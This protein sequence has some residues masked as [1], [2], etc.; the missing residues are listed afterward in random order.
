VIA[1]AVERHRLMTGDDSLE[2]D[3]GLEL[4]VETA[5]LWISLGH[6]DA[7]GD[8]HI[9]GVTGPTST[10]RSS[11]TTSSPTSW[12]P[13]TCGRR[14]TPAPA[15]PGGRAAWAPPRGDRVLAPRGQGV[16][17]PVRRG[18]RRPPAVGVVHPLRRVGLRGDEDDYPLLLHVP[19]FQLYR[20]QVI[21]Q[22]DLVLAMHWCPEAFDEGRRPATSTTTSAGPSATR[23]CRRAR[24]R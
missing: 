17:R 19:Y 21:K 8:W 24:R 22:A 3:Y 10:P 6:H 13:A 20:K 2:V 12:P 11:T 4:L 1:H 18:A 16:H 23:R 7:H 9:D 15:T 14:P 5:R